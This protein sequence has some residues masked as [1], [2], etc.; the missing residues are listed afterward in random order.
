M[1]SQNGEEAV[2]KSTRRALRLVVAYAGG[3]ANAANAALAAPETPT[4]SGHELSGARE[5]GVV[6]AC[7][8]EHLSAVGVELDYPGAGVLEAWI[9]ACIDGEIAMEQLT[10]LAP[11]AARFLPKASSAHG[12]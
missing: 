3:L 5:S 8:L 9:C 12:I 11:A 2:A 10:A 6:L 4:L 1:L 7:A